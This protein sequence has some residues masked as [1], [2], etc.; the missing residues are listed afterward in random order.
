MGHVH[1]IYGVILILLAIVATAWE[2]ASKSG[3]PKPFRGI[4][5]GL[6]DLQVILGIITWIVRRPHW[7]FIGHPILMIVAVIILHVM[8]S[9]R[10]AR[11]RRIAGWIIALVL[12]IIGAGAYHA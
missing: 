5:I 11:S 2:I 9:L 8:T 12:L 3:L 4:V 7:Q 1:M 10:Y 6:F